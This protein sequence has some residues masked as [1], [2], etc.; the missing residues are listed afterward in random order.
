MA[1]ANTIQPMD[2]ASI[3][4]GGASISSGGGGWS[5][6][7]DGM[8]DPGPAPSTGVPNQGQ[9]QPPPTSGYDAT[10]YGNAGGGGGTGVVPTD[11][12][13]QPFAQYGGFTNGANQ[14][15]GQLSAQGATFGAGAYGTLAPAVNNAGVAQAWQQSQGAEAQQAGAVAQLRSA[16]LGQAPSAAA[17]G[18]QNQIAGNTAGAYAAGKLSGN[19]SAAGQSAGQGATNAIGTGLGARGNELTSA[20][21][22]YSGAANNLT[23]A[24]VNDASQQQQLALA[25]AQQ[26]QQANNQN[27]GMDLYYQQQAQQVNAAQLQANT[28]MLNTEQGNA[29]QLGT[30]QYSFGQ[31]NLQSLASAGLGASSGLATSMMQ[32]DQDQGGPSASDLANSMTSAP[33]EADLEDPNYGGDS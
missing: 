13:G 20:A 30:Q 5:Y 21:G 26:Q 17:I 28:S 24:A 32:P 29:A 11:Q 6:G 3:S 14:I 33:T 19:M 7:T 16:A 4:S 12:F 9:G 18:Q 1:L 2:A 27:Q 23:G 22:A 8:P 25:S 10:Y 15:S 31:Q